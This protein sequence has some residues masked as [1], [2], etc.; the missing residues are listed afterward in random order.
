MSL[1][2]KTLSERFSDVQ[3][4]HELL[5]HYLVACFVCSTE[6]NMSYMG[7]VPLDVMLRCTKTRWESFLPGEWERDLLRKGRPHISCIVMPSQA[8]WTKLY[9]DTL[10]EESH[11]TELFEVASIAT[12]SLN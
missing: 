7:R 10:P 1:Q 12:F 11:P 9:R 6:G 2:T 3:A 4:T 5:G 8:V